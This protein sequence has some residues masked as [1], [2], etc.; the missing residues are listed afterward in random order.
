MFNTHR[1]W[2]LGIVIFRQ[3]YQVRFSLQ[4]GYRRHPWCHST[5]I[6]HT[7]TSTSTLCTV[8]INAH[9]RSFSRFSFSFPQRWTGTSLP[10]F[11]CFS[12]STDSPRNTWTSAIRYRRQ[13]H[14]LA[15]Q[16]LLSNHVKALHIKTE[17][18]SDLRCWKS[19]NPSGNGQ[20][21]WNSCV[22][23]VIEWWSKIKSNDMVTISLLWL[24]HSMPSCIYI[25]CICPNLIIISIDI[26]SKGYTNL[27][28]LPYISIGQFAQLNN[29]DQLVYSFRTSLPINSMLI[30]SVMT[31]S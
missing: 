29:I 30:K 4:T 19:E 17:S 9:Y 21:P 18:P 5:E 2:K 10:L 1:N 11:F 28:I 16:P 20:P 25:I 22:F 23:V 6:I 27:I 8:A 7:S 14:T 15:I 31:K 24:C 13:N 26:G 3:D 12:R